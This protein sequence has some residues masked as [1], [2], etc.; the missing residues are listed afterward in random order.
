MQVCS[1]V[2]FHFISTKIPQENLTY[3]ADATDDDIYELER[4]FYIS[5]EN[6]AEY[7]ASMVYVGVVHAGNRVKFSI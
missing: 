3:P 1:K 4:T 5:E 2:V 7:N 6:L